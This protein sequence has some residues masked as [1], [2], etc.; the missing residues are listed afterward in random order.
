MT[1]E[2]DE[3]AGATKHTFEALASAVLALGVLHAEELHRLVAH[4]RG[5]AET[6]AGLAACLEHADRHVAL[7]LHAPLLPLEPLA[8]ERRGLVRCRSEALHRDGVVGTCQLLAGLP[9]LLLPPRLAPHS[10]LLLAR[11]RRCATAVIAAD[12]DAI[13]H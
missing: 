1:A 5:A 9:Q 8:H 7:H 11:H 4:L 13:L 10:L 3:A 12:A 6:L 2:T